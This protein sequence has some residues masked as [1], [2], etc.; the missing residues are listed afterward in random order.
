MS[1]SQR[2]RFYVLSESDLKCT[3]LYRHCSLI[4]LHIH[5]SAYTHT[6]SQLDYG[7]LMQW[8]FSPIRQT[9]YRQH[10][11]TK[12][13][14]EDDTWHETLNS[15]RSTFLFSRLIWIKEKLFRNIDFGIIWK[16]LLDHYV[17]K[18]VQISLTCDF[19][20]TDRQ[21]FRNCFSQISQL[22]TSRHHIDGT[23]HQI[24]SLNNMIP[25]KHHLRPFFSLLGFFVVVHNL[26]HILR[27]T[28]NFHIF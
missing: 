19:I 3:A 7:H 18:P 21:H 26:L 15:N 11:Y 9:F 10:W 6:H 22:K 24:T 5:K 2:I 23:S 14:Q 25:I 20:P 17:T 28:Y 8:H 13:P 16:Y 4:H 27:F 12:M 1:Q